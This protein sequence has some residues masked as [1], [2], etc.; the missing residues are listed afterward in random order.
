MPLVHGGAHD[1]AFP[2]VFDLSH[3]TEI[4][5]AQ[6][7]V[8]VALIAVQVHDQ[9]VAGADLVDLDK[10]VYSHFTASDPDGAHSTSSSRARVMPT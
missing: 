7:H 4:L 2:I 1:A 6:R 10:C 5:A 8:G 3:P 9:E